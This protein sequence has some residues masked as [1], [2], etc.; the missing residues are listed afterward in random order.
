MCIC[1][2]LWV[3][4]W[5]CYCVSLLV[6]ARG[7]PW[8]LFLS[9]PTGS[10]RVSLFSTVY[11][12]LDEMHACSSLPV[13]ALQLAIGSLAL[14]MWAAMPGMVWVLG[15]RTHIL[16]FAQQTLW[17]LSHHTTPKFSVFDTHTPTSCPP[18]TGLGDEVVYWIEIQQRSRAATFETWLKK[19]TLLPIFPALC[20]LLCHFMPLME[21]TCYVVNYPVKNFTRWKTQQIF[22]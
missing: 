1:V 16:M 4:V 11:R 18:G 3:R 17:L 9:F 8:E 20:C 22:M 19:N 15:I 13:S 7:Q 10:G 2:F 12:R 5:M 14:W 21:A 6:E